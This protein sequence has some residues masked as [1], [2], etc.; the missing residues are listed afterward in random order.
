MRRLMPNAWQSAAKG[1]RCFR[2][3]CIKRARSPT[4]EKIFHGMSAGEKHSSKM[5]TVTHVYALM[6]YPCLC[7]VPGEGAGEA[8]KNRRWGLAP[9]PN[10]GAGSHADPGPRAKG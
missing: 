9:S 8:R 6:C 7:P 10:P 3:A 2:A 5:K 4:A 1:L